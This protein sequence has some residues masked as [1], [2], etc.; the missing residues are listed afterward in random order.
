MT[1]DG[2]ET[3][4]QQ[5]ADERIRALVAAHYHAPDGPVPRDAMW[6]AVR[7]ARA[8]EQAAEQAAERGRVL[9]FRTIRR[10]PHWVWGPALAAGLLLGILVDRALA[11]STTT[12]VAQHTPAVTAAA[13]PS[14]PP[15]VATTT[16]PGSS[17]APRV[18]PTV[19]A[20]PETA[21]RRVA[22]GTPRVGEARV[23]DA[24]PRPATRQL[25]ER[26]APL[27]DARD[28][29]RAV[30]TQTLVQAEALLTA[31][32]LPDAERQD[33][34]SMRQTARWSREVLSSTRLL[35][36]S[37]AG[38]DPRLRQLLTDLELVLAQIV[39]LSGAPLQA[40]ERELIERAMRERDLIPRLRAA[41]PA[42][43]SA[44]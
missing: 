16:E 11:P 29:Y 31:Y 6:T 32:R 34:E 25:A 39:Q 13:A 43:A 27:P 21:P 22:T 19:T 44:T 36:D 33:A 23:P 5:A 38:R 14:A 40:G 26:A 30:A 20:A 37:P 8:A 4:E 42:G 28:L 41:A 35:L 2:F 15:T 7:A 3:F 12:T 1:D 9:P 18:T 10:A 24:P 17:A